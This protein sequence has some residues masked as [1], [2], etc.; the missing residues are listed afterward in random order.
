[1]MLADKLARKARSV[2][3]DPGGARDV[4]AALEALLDAAPSDRHPDHPR[5]EESEI[6]RR[7]GELL[8]SVADLAQRSGIDAEQ[9]LRAYAFTWRD[10]IMAAEGLPE[11]TEGSH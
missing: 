1:L 5:A 7:V 8:F 6:D 4:L 2:G 3:L 11:E 10:E 9:A